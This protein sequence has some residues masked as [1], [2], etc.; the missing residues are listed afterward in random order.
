MGKFEACIQDLVPLSDTFNLRIMIII[1]Q[2]FE[3]VWKLQ[4]FSVGGLSLKFSCKVVMGFKAENFLCFWE[5]EFIVGRLNIVL[6]L[7]NLV[8]YCENR[9][10]AHSPSYE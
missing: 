5:E 9:F 3:K 2:I 6:L 10:G 1:I 8:V 7:H 4:F